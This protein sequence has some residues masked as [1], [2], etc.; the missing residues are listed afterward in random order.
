VNA[1]NDRLDRMVSREWLL[2]GVVVYALADAFVDAHFRDFKIEFEYDP[3]LPKG[4]P[5]ASGVRLAAGW[6]F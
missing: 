6:A 4:T 3:A 1:Y 5:G 2:G